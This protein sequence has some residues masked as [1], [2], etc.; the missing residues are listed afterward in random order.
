MYTRNSKTMSDLNKFAGSCVNTVT[1]HLLDKTIICSK[2]STNLAFFHLCSLL[3]GFLF[4][5]NGGYYDL[6]FVISCYQ[7]DNRSPLLLWEF[8]SITSLHLFIICHFSNIPFSP[9]AIGVALNALLF[10]FSRIS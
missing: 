10:V 2:F 1:I 9:D 5:P 7:S 8:F 6:S 4:V 3:A